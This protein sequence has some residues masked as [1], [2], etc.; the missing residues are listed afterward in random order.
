MHRVNRAW[1]DAVCQGLETIVVQ[2]GRLE[3]LKQFPNVNNYGFE[4]IPFL[5]VG[6]RWEILKIRLREDLIPK[7]SYTV[8]AAKGGL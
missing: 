1:R 7:Y 5:P 4:R 2:K 8:P 3:T 6:S